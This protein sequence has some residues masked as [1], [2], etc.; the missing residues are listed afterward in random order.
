MLPVTHGDALNQYFYDSIQI[1]RLENLSI[2]DYYQIG[3]YF[4]TDSFAS[5]FDAIILQLTDNW[6]LVRTVRVLALILVIL[7]SLEMTLNIGN[8]N[9]KREFY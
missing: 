3:E 9:F 2:S 6:F 7:N 4:R 8:I 1:S 5:F